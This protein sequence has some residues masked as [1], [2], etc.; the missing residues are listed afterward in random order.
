MHY[1]TIQQRGLIFYVHTDNTARR[2]I[3][4]I[5]R[6]KKEEAVVLTT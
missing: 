1:F 3:P 6:D 2:G 4:T 5:N